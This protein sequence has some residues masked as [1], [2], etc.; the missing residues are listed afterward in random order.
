[1]NFEK[2]IIMTDL[3]GTLL[4]DKKR[5]SEKDLSAINEFRKKGGSFTLATGRGIA[6][7]RNVVEKLEIDMPC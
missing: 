3:D 1:M 5:V 4:D 6:M 7:A 2:V